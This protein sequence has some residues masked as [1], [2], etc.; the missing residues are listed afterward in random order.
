MSR[1]VKHRAVGITP[2]VLAVVGVGGEHK[3]KAI[4]TPQELADAWGWPLKRAQRMF[5][6]IVRGEPVVFATTDGHGMGDIRIDG[7]RDWLR[8]S[9]HEQLERLRKLLVAPTGSAWAGGNDDLVAD[10]K[11]LTEAQMRPHALAANYIRIGDREFVNG[12]EQKGEV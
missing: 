10:L 11:K 5:A 12:V 9:N 1:L 8:E 3:P 6:D 4:T 2:G 7:G